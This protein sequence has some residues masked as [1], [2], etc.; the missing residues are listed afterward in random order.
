MQLPDTEEERACL[1]ISKLSHSPSMTHFFGGG[2]SKASKGQSG[3]QFKETSSGRKI[4]TLS[5]I[6]D[7]LG[8][9]RAMINQVPAIKTDLSG[10][11]V[12]KHL[13]K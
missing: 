10:H 5:R 2:S 9:D 8:I 3:Y 4:S 6:A 11:A 12:A 1:H 13:Q 7:E